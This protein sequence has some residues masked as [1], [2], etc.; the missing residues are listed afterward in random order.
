MMT[1]CFLKRIMA[2]AIA[3]LAVLACASQAMAN[4]SSV[5]R[6]MYRLYNTHSGEHFYTASVAER[7]SLRQSGWRWEGVGWVAPAH[8]GTPVYR[9]YNPNAG[10]HHYTLNSNEKDSLIRAGWR[11]E[12]IGWYSSDGTHAYPLYREYNPHAKSGAHNYTLNH[13]EDVN[14]T[15]A[16]WRAEG[17][18]WYAVGGGHGAPWG[19]ASEQ[20]FS[21]CTAVRKAG[22]APIYRGDPGYSPKLDRD[23]DGI[24][25]E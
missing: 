15:R 14:L 20:P 13:N 19:N 24:A 12:G 1:R 9:L 6:E 8:S 17:I 23:N 7:N 16:G 4:D 21:N 3:M 22:R 2:A 10:D 5:S 25:C 18:S 11:Y